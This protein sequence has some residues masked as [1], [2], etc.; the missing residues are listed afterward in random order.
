M[1]LPNI[2]LYL[3]GYNFN[4][5]VIFIPFGV[6]FKLIFQIFYPKGCNI[7]EM[8]SSFAEKFHYG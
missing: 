2:F 4:K 5:N 6:Y 3:F 1:Q 8:S 7:S